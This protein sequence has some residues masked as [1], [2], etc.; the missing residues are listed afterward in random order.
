MFQTLQYPIVICTH[1]Y[2]RTYISVLCLVAQS[3]P[4]LCD[5]TDRSLPG[6]SIHGDSPGKNTG[7][8][9]HALLQ[10]NLPNPGTEPRSPSLQADICATREAHEYWTA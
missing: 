10:G 4:N 6:S 7:V 2:V 8:G 1:I 3:C 5:P 9:C